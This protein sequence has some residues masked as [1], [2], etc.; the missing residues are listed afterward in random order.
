MTGRVDTDVFVVGA[1][2]VGLS[3]SIALRRFGVECLIV[4]RHAGTLDFPRGRGVSVRTMEIM[5]RWGLE[6]ALVAVGLPR[7][8]SLAVFSGESLLAGQFERV[9]R[10]V[11]RSSALSPT[12]PL[13]CDQVQMEAVLRDAAVAAGADVRFGWELAHI[14]DDGDTIGASLVEHGSGR[15]HAVRASWLVAADGAHSATRERLG[16]GRHG[17]GVVGAAVSILIE[18]DLGDRMTDRLSVLYR[19][20]GLPGGTV[21]AVDNDRRWLLIYGYD[22][23]DQRTE[24]FTD[25]RLRELALAAIGDD[26]VEFAIVGHRF[27]QPT[28]LV[29]DHYRH[30]RIFLAGDSAHVCT[31]IGGLGMNCGLSDVD[32]LAWKLAGVVS[33]WADD[34]LLNTYELERRPVA[35]LTAEASL[36]RA[37]PPAQVD[38]LHL[39]TC[40][41]SAAI[42]EDGTV[43]PEPAD[44]IGEYV[45]V[46]RP[47]HRAPHLWLDE[48]REHSTLDLFGDAFVL[49]TAPDGF[50][51]RRAA[52]ATAGIPLEV[53]EILDTRWP[54]LYG[55]CSSGAVLVRPDGHVA[56]RAVHAP[57][58]PAELTTALRRAVGCP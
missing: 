18:A 25:A 8:E 17:T 24:S 53:H 52:A 16:I 50:A 39:G 35:E 48:G 15:E 32:N 26:R 11:P 36:G 43:R 22:P 31:P 38:G 21:A 3:M 30:G 2:P 46:A 55:I 51:W 9:V 58:E 47:G 12:E 42:A 37:R 19:L 4:E 49:L 40:Y 33:G 20:S 13:I 23:A 27:W 6:E 54:E 10:Q 1:G 41:E 5:R 28:A 45:P 29:S 34:A 56:W 7:S 44:P 14:A 57:G